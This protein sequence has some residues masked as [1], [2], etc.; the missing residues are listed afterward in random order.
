MY[1]NMIASNNMGIN[2]LANGGRTRNKDKALLR[3]HLETFTKVVVYMV[4]R[5][6]RICTYSLKTLSA[7]IIYTI[8]VGCFKK[9][10][11]ESR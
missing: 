5:K 8:M 11:R 1:D 7:K 2:I 4:R 6:A 9:G 3:C 10:V